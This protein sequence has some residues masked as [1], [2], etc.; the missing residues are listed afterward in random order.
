MTP[1]AFDKIARAL[2]GV[3]YTTEMAVALGVSTTAVYRYAKGLRGISPS[4]QRQLRELKD[5][6]LQ[7][8]RRISIPVGDASDAGS[9]DV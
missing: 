5:R 1:A 6:R 9:E 3:N 4:V 2:Y 8:I 7:E